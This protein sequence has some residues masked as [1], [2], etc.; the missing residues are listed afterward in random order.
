M[1]ELV[2]LIFFCGFFF[3]KQK[4][5]YGIRLSLVGSGM[6]IGDS[7]GSVD[8]QVKRV[9]CVT[10]RAVRISIRVIT[11][12]CVGGA[13]PG[14]TITNRNGCSCWKTVSDGQVPRVARITT[15]CTCVVFYILFL[16]HT[17]HSRPNDC[18]KFR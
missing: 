17:V 1:V 13:I 3:F 18:W 11:R 6:C 12:L 9:C 10:S 5:G 2:S 4:T 14:I 16:I 15:V 8:R 7:C